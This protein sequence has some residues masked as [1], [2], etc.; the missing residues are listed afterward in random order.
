MVGPKVVA[1]PRRVGGST[2]EKT[3]GSVPFKLSQKEDKL[4]EPETRAEPRCRL[5]CNNNVNL[6]VSTGFSRRK[7]LEEKSTHCRGEVVTFT[8]TR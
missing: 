6:F 5:P 2:E 8:L 4:G 7:K 1:S 3:V